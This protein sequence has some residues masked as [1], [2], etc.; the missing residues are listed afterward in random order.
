MQSEYSLTSFM[1]LIS[2]RQKE[3]IEATGMIL[4]EQGVSGL[5]TKNLA[6]RMNFSESA[7]YRHF[8]NKTDILVVHIRYLFNN[9]R[10]R[11]EGI[12]VAENTVQRSLEMFMESQFRFLSQ[13]RHFVVAMLS[14]TLLDEGSPV[15]EVCLEMFAYVQQFFSNLMR[16]GIATGEIGLRFSPEAVF[17]CVMGAFRA[18]MLRWKLS[19]FGF[20][21]EEE[22]NRIMKEV[23]QMALNK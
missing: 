18:V 19:D 17:H 1:N 15:R 23:I 5:T 4:T 7:L 2:E 12:P 11:L 10:E 22:G 20:D 14:E 3:I 9:V 8:R 6:A 13:N 16:K 21:L